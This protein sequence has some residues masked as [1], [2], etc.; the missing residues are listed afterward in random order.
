MLKP[1]VW[2]LISSTLTRK[3]EARYQLTFKG[4]RVDF[5]RLT[6]PL[7][8]N[9]LAR[10]ILPVTEILSA[11]IDWRSCSRSFS[12][13]CLTFQ[14]SLAQK[15]CQAFWQQGFKA[16]FKDFSRFSSRNVAKS[17]SES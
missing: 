3:V 6:P 11:L 10:D 13:S 5:L 14:D 8:T 17:F 2:A 4:F 15:F 16:F 1:P 7:V 9:D 12:V